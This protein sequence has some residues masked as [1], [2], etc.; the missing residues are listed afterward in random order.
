MPMEKSSFWE[1]K[2]KLENTSGILV[3]IGGIHEAI[4]KEVAPGSR[5]I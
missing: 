2:K 4:L 3:S 1:G 5:S